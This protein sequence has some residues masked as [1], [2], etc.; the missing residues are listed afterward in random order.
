MADAPSDIVANTFARN[1]GGGR[2]WRWLLQQLHLWTGLVLCVPLVLLGLTGS[3]LVFQDELRDLAD[4][5]PRSQS[6]EAK[7]PSAIIAAAATKIP[8][9]AAPSLFIA[10]ESPGDLAS[11]RFAQRGAAPGPGGIQVFVDPVSLDVLGVRE[12]NAGIVRQIF[13]LHANLLMRDRS[14]RAVIGWLGV[15]MC[16]LG[17]TGLVLWWPRSGQWRA[18]FAIRQ[19]ARGLRLHRDL[20]GMVGIWGVIVFLIV[21][22]SGTYLAFPQAIGAATRAIMPARDLR[23]VP[24]VTPPAGER[25]QPLD[26]DAAVALAHAAGVAGTL[27]TIALP[28]RPDQAVRLGF[29]PAGAGHGQPPATVFIDPWTHRV[30]EVRD[31]RAFTAAETAL[32]WQ[33][34]LHA[35]EGL[36]WLWKLLV[37]ASGFMPALFVITGLSMWLIKRRAKRAVLP[38]RLPAVKPA[39]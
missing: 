27:R 24:T 9:G 15:A 11:V 10:P 13:M 35:G 21:S 23:A 22:V 29:L 26:A 36:G 2:R 32:V 16:G 38:R 20:H 30:I 33:H 19:G 39:E 25:P 17:V 37:F 12:P 1:I 6:G 34:S 5:L 7:S 3:V 28:N 4:P 14:G 31:P 18:A 8:S